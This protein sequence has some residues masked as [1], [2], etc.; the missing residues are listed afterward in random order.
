MFSREG[1]TS[2]PTSKETNSFLEWTYAIYPLPDLS[3]RRFRTWEASIL[4]LGRFHYQ[5]LRLLRAAL[6]QA[7][8][9][10]SWWAPRPLRGS[11]LTPR[12]PHTTSVNT[13]PI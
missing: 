10:A 6:G 11:S 12:I 4:G 2:M 13:Q 8:S 9:P 5:E 3:I 7:P 1:P